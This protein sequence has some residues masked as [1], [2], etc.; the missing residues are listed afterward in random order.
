MLV[1][2]KAGLV[3]VL[4]TMA[5]IEAA[6]QEHT[7][8]KRL[9]TR[10]KNGLS[11]AIDKQ[12][13]LEI[14]ESRFME[15]KVKFS[16]VQEK[17]EVYVLLRDSIVE[18]FDNEE[19]YTWINEIELVYEDM[20]RRKVAYVQAQKKTE[21]KKMKFKSNVIELEAHDKK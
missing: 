5:S 21:E 20:E 14:I 19:E 6:K 1:L 12:D 2:G 3:F 8:A 17:H 10:I 15:L 16:K 13:D 7:T 9:F 11:N 18:E 4:L